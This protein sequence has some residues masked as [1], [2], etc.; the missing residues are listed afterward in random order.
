MNDASPLDFCIENGLFFD[1]RGGEPAVRHLGIRDGVVVEVSEA[2]IAR[3][4]AERVIDATDRWVM[5][6][7]VDLHT[8][9]DAEVEVTPALSESVRHGVTTIFMG[10]CSL[11]ASLGEP[12][13]IA[14]IF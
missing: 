6:G 1:G 2:P 12:E 3:E 11:G 8:H 9:Y 5:P 14:D 13:D 10:S 7:F 4:R